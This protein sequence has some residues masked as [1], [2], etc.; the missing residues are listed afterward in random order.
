MKTNFDLS[1]IIQNEEIMGI[2][3]FSSKLILPEGP[4][5]GFRFSPQDSVLAKHLW[6]YMFGEKKGNFNEF[7]ITGPSQSGKSLVSFIIPSIYISYYQ[8]ENSIL[9]SPTLT[10]I[11]K[12][13]SQSIMEMILQNDFLR[14]RLLPHTLHLDLIMDHLYRLYQHN[15]QIKVNHQK[16]V[17]IYLSQNLVVLKECLPQMKQMQLNNYEQE[18]DH[19][20]Q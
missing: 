16:L 6:P 12:K 9:S 8:Q 14:H 20:F 7:I 18:L 5:K 11:Q 19:S 3:D 17:E 10:L 2:E 15:H 13:F 1:D 4:R